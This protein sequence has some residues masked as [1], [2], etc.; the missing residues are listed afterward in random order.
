MCMTVVCEIS[1][2]NSTVGSCVFI[3]KANTVYSLGHDGLH[4]L[5]AVP[6]PIQLSTVCRREK[7]GFG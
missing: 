2:S 3:V 1:G 5:T 7:R 4:T 6:R